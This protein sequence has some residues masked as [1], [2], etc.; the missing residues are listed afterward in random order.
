MLLASI[1][2]GFASAGSST[3]YSH[4]MSDKLG[5]DYLGVTDKVFYTNPRNAPVGDTLCFKISGTAKSYIEN[6]YVYVKTSLWGFSGYWD[7]CDSD[8]FDSE[9]SCPL[10]AGDSWEISDCATLPSWLW[11]TTVT[12]TATA[13][14]DTKK[15]SKVA[16]YKSSIKLTKSSSSMAQLS[17]QEQKSF[18][19]WTTETPLEYHGNTTESGLPINGTGIVG[20][21]VASLL[22]VGA[23]GTGIICFF[24]KPIFGECPWG[25]YKKLPG[26]NTSAPDGFGR[27]TSGDA[28]QI[29]LSK[30]FDYG[31]DSKRSSST[32]EAYQNDIR[33]TLEKKKNEVL[34]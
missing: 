19:G 22:V 30:P 32:L 7:M 27:T 8:D 5:H 28:E 34:L 3:Y 24:G 11:S 2:V 12:A 21:V 14:S 15:S 31:L 18:S 4:S 13:Y 25:N 1:L 16:I 10:N 20:L 9:L 33:L 26:T 29:D 17:S 6:P 23:I